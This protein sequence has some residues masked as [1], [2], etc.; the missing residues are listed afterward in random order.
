M[1]IPILIEADQKQPVWKIANFVKGIYALKIDPEIIY[2]SYKSDYIINKT[3]PFNFKLSFN[4]SSKKWLTA[5]KAG[6][7]YFDGNMATVIGRF[8][9]TGSEIFFDPSQEEKYNASSY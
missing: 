1:F 7:I 9:K 4:A 6:N 2:D 3:A 5:M 8:R